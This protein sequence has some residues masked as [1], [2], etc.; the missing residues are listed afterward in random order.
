MQHTHRLAT[1]VAALSLLTFSTAAFADGPWQTSGA[2][3]RKALAACGTDV[4]RLCPAVTPGGGRIANCL[5]AQRER[6]TP[7][8]NSF[9][10]RTMATR[11]VALACN[12][13]AARLCGDVSP[14]GGR[15]AACLYDQLDR[16]SVDCRRAMRRAK[17]AAYH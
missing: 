8:C 7:R 9:L 12:N 6:L 10:R 15:I 3:G 1:A 17:A 5:I 4:S 11:N 13:D 14:G 2:F 16:L